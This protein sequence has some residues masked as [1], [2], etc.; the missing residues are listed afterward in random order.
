MMSKKAELYQ[1]ILEHMDFTESISD[2]ELQ[3]LI[4]EVL[5]TYGREVYLSIEERIQ[6]GKEL[7]NS[8]RKLDILQELLEDDRI[9][10]I[11][12]NGLD[13]IFVEKEGKLQQLSRKFENRSKLEDVI[14]Q[15]VAGTNRIVNESSPLVDARLS[16]GSRVHIALPPIA[17]NGPILTIRKF[18]KESIGME[19]LLGWGSISKEMVVFL[20]KLVVGKYNILISGGTGSG[21]TTFLNALSEYIPSDE[22]IITIEDNAELQLKQIPNLVRMEARNMNVEGVGEITI[23]NL[24]RQS[25]RM[26]PDRVVVGEVR[27]EEAIDMLT[28]MNTGHDGSLCTAHANTIADMLTRLET[29]VLMGVDIPLEAIRRQIASAIDVM[30]HVSRLR[31]GSRKV[32]E[33]SE[34]LGV[35]HNEIQLSTIYKFQ[36]EEE[37]NDKV[38]GHWNYVNPLVHTEKLLAAGY[39]IL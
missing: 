22:R 19:Q 12:I 26:R 1:L 28:V 24:I 17:L 4:Y 37:A 18:P 38:K 8:F 23:R 25:L 7:F 35:E 34:V 20:E 21:K 10:E 33:V 27:S 5:R 15:I 6:L 29:M 14:Q 36:E 9:T 32:L 2:L 30:V 11:M 3:E 16:D 39:S 13:N 31:D